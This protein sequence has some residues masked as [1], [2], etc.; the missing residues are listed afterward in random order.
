MS[1]IDSCRCAARRRQGA[2]RPLVCGD[3]AADPID[4]AVAARC[5]RIVERTDDGGFVELRAVV[6][7]ARCAIEVQ[8]AMLCDEDHRQNANFMI[9]MTVS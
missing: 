8:N 1:D 7:A 3:S 4:P 5:G 6:D 9:S 2:E